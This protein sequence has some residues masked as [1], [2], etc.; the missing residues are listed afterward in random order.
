MVFEAVTLDLIV[1]PFRRVKFLHRVLFRARRTLLGIPKFVRYER[2]SRHVIR[3]TDLSDKV[4]PC[5]L[6]HFDHSPRSGKRGLVLTDSTPD[7]IGKLLESLLIRFKS[8]TTSNKIIFIK[9]WNECGEGK[10]LEPDLK[11][12]K[13]YLGKNTESP[14]N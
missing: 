12:G 14:G 1:E 3:N 8:V 4:F 11:Y 2:Y 6:P 13:R 7:N 10:Y 9:S 5:I